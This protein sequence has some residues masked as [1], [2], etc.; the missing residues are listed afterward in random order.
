MASTNKD[1]VKHYIFLAQRVNAGQIKGA[2]QRAIRREAHLGSK[3][4]DVPG[5]GHYIWVPI[6]WKGWN[7]S[8]VPHHPQVLWV[9]L[10]HHV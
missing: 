4:S 2:A 5:I 8:C 3:V 6:V 10:D 9:L 1:Y 7:F